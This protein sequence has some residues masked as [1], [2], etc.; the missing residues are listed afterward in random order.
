M[1]VCVYAC[2]RVLEPKSTV[3]IRV[4]MVS[5]VA[6]SQYK[7]AD[8]THEFLFVLFQFKFHAHV[9]VEKFI[10]YCLHMREISSGAV[11]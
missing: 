1:H 5:T 10:Y 7:R 3:K 2:L 11:E 9:I 8:K 4:T 6:T